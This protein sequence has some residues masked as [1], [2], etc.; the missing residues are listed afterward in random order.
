MRSLCKAC[1]GWIALAVVLA[2]G[3]PAAAQTLTGSVGGTVKDQQGGVLP[4]VTVTLTGR[5]GARTTTTDES[6]SYRFTA[7]EPGTYTIKA[8]IQGFTA[9]A[10]QQLTV[11][12]S[13][14][15]TVD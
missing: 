1:V 2:A 10:E 9:P 7:L 6:G 15:L 4:G 13:N 3:M 14:Q 5:T 11:N 12:V 8:Q